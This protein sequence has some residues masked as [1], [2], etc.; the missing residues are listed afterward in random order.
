MDLAD[1][2]RLRSDLRE[3][4]SLL[5][6]L[7]ERADD[8][9][10][11]RY[12]DLEAKYSQKLDHLQERVQSLSRDGKEKTASLKDEIVHQ[13]LRIRLAR[14]EIDELDSLLQ[15]GAISEDDHQKEK[16]R[17][18]L[19]KEGA[20]RKL[21]G[22]RKELDEIDFYLNEVGDV[23][24]SKEKVRDR[25]SD[26]TAW[27]SDTWYRFL[28][29]TWLM[30]QTRYFR[31]LVVVVLIVGVG[32]LTYPH[33]QENSWSAQRLFHVITMQPDPGTMYRGGEARTGLYSYEAILARPIEAWAFQS[34]SRIRST[35]AVANDAVYL[36]SDD[37]TVFAAALQNG[38]PL[39]E[40][41]TSGSY[42][43]SPAVGEDAAFIGNMNGKVLALNAESGA[44]VWSYDTGA[45]VI[46]SPLLVNEVVYVGSRNGQIYALDRSNG[47]LRWKADTGGEV[48][49]SPSSDGKTVF[50]GNEQGLV[51]A[52][53]I[54]TGNEKWVAEVDAG[55]VATSPFIDGKV[56]VRSRQGAIYAF[57]A[58][59]GQRLWRQDVDRGGSASVAVSR[60]YVIASTTSGEVQAYRLEDGS[61][62]WM[63]AY[64]E[65]FGYSPAVVGN[66]VI[67]RSRHSVLSVGLD[68][69]ETHWSLET[70]ETATT[71]PVA[72][73]S[74]LLVAS[75]N[76]L[77][78]FR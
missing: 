35:P 33:I 31:V 17:F 28:D 3:T 46:S 72:A 34:T 53:D 22:L 4:R 64:D 40:T 38:Q 18:S 45:A 76:Q 37:G 43:S 56:I 25:L 47:D 51:H 2:P 24:Y 42:T 20:K 14:K 74:M 32:A 58:S 30:R 50:V 52:F 55:V 60:D 36:A 5:A 10:T 67:L 15:D 9:S 29:L 57:A 23:S 65:P 21:R 39:W 11:S 77:Q 1:L 48:Y 63:T 41:E 12:D 13:R 54:E 59:S 78:A 73:G 62:A 6:R 8:V 16:Q 44:Q 71:S 19:R 75:G 69:G 27:M 70:E 49:S 68:T 66:H 7:K 26:S 61:R